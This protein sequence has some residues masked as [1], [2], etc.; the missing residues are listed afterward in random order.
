MV[1]Y[2]HDVHPFHFL[3]L[4]L[5]MTDT[6]VCRCH[7]LVLHR[8]YSTKTIDYSSIC[9]RVQLHAIIFLVPILTSLLLQN[10]QFRTCSHGYAVSTL[11]LSRR[12]QLT[13][14]FIHWWNIF[15]THKTHPR[16]VFWKSVFQLKRPSSQPARRVILC[17]VSVDFPLRSGSFHCFCF[18]HFCDVPAALTASPPP[19][20]THLLE[21]NTSPWMAPVIL[22][23]DRRLP[24]AV[25]LV[26]S[27]DHSTAAPMKTHLN[28]LCLHVGGRK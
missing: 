24:F 8:S 23:S 2:T 25:C 28:V 1:Y 13:M 6:D 5:T 22:T 21:A 3:S 17:E 15:A 7:H 20:V 16:A 4:R 18:L 12:E 19:P 10:M 11:I 14:T 26:H 27:P 9:I